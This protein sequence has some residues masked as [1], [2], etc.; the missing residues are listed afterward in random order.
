MKQKTIAEML[1]E[2]F[3]RGG[4]LLLALEEVPK[5]DRWHCGFC[6]LEIANCK[7]AD[8]LLAKKSKPPTIH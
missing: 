4:N 2:E 7:C 6:K 8:R 1:E 5:A 3:A